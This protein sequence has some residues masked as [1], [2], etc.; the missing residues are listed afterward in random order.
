MDAIAGLRL[1]WLERERFG[2]NL[3]RGIVLEVSGSCKDRGCKCY[4]PKCD[5]VERTTKEGRR[6]ETRR[7]AKVCSLCHFRLRQPAHK[8]RVCWKCSDAMADLVRR[9]EAFLRDNDIMR[10]PQSVMEE[11]REN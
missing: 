5:D 3:W 9:L 8:D 10:S 6:G 4:C 2:R 7:K 11:L 1:Y